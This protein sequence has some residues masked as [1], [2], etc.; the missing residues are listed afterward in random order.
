[1]NLIT[2][3]KPKHINYNTTSIS[4]IAGFLPPPKPRNDFFMV[5]DYDQAKSILD[6]LISQNA[7]IIN[8]EMGLDGDWVEN[9][10]EIF[11][12]KDHYPYDSHPESDWAEPLM[13]VYFEDRPN[14]AYSVWKKELKK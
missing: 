12:G 11:D 7:K 10:T 8:A 4:W 1:M 3:Y 6:Y 14:E 5:A 9:N 2:N 13:I